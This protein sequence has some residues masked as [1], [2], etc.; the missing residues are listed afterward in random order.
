MLMIR[1]VIMIMIMMI[2]SIAGLLMALDIPQERGMANLPKKWS[3]PDACFFPLFDWMRPLPL[4]WMYML[5][6]VM[7]VAAVGIMLGLFYRLSCCCFVLTYWYVFFMDKTS[8]N[9][10]SYLY[11]LTGSM[12]LLTNAHHYWLV[13]TGSLSNFPGQDLYYRLK[14]W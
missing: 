2:A 11:G 10:H 5:Y 7:F 13:C 3:D 4:D 6:V 8:W 14:Y 12:L 1:A 9:N